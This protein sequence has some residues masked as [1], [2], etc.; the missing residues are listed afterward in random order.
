MEGD[1]IGLSKQLLQGHK[2]VGPFF[3]RPRRVAEQDV[4]AQAACHGLH[5]LA[6]VSYADNADGSPIQLDG[7]PGGDAVEGAEDV[8][9]HSP[10]VAALGVL[11]VYPVRSTPGQVDV[12]HADGGAGNHLHPRPG[13][14]FLVAL[15]ARTDDDGI[16]VYHGSV[17]NGPAVQVDDIGIGFQYTLQERDVGVRYNLHSAERRIICR[18]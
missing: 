17:V 13:K 10:G 5:L 6:H 18:I 16:G 7:P 11:H 4:E 14:G 9:S 12:I 1:D 15:G 3:Q 8:I 2:G